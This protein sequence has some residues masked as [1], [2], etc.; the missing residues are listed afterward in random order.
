MYLKNADIS[1]KVAGRLMTDEFKPH[2][3]VMVCS[4]YED[5]SEKA[6]EFTRGMTASKENQKQDK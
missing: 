6:H 1:L 3:W 5:A 2:L 4:Y